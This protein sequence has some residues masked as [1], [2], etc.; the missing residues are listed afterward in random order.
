VAGT[1]VTSQTARSESARRAGFHRSDIEH[2][3]R[4]DP[5]AAECLEADG[6]VF[7]LLLPGESFASFQPEVGGYAFTNAINR[8][9]ETAKAKGLLS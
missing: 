1:Q 2:L 4:L 3:N 5:A 9:Q 8:L 6:E 7:P